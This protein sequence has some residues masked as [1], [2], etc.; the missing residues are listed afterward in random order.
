M[1]STHLQ[2]QAISQFTNENTNK[3]KQAH[4]DWIDSDDERRE[5]EALSEGDGKA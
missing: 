4:S 1:R 5:D 3:S 2:H